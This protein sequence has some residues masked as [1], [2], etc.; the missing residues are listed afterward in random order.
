[1]NRSHPTPRS[2]STAELRTALRGVVGPA[3]PDYLSDIVAEAG[4]TRQRPA[5]TFL[6]RWLPVDIGEQGLGVPRAAVVF[7]VLSLLV[8]LLVAPAV[9]VGSQTKPA[10]VDLGIFA[11]VAGRVVY[12]DERGIWGV[13]A[14]APADGAT[15]VQLTSEAGIPLGWSSDGT[16]LL[17]M[18]GS[19]PDEHL[20]VLHADGSETQ[21]TD[22]PMSIRGATIAPDGSRVVFAAATSEGGSALYAVD[23]QGGSAEVLVVRADSG[24]R[25]PAYSPAGTRI[26]YMSG[27]GDHSNSVWLMN[28]DG[29][30]DHPIVRNE[31]D[32]WAGHVGGLAW[33]PTGEQIALGLGGKIYTFATDGSGFT[34]I[35]GADTTCISPED[36]AINLPKSVVSPY[37]SPDGSQNAYT[38]GCLEGARATNRD[39]CHLAIADADGSN[40]LVFGFA[41]SGPWHP[42]RR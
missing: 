16:R 35:A 13:D 25:A 10:P 33:S 36:C 28:A 42:A 22:R 40:V 1:M 18:R 2:F 8:A 39:G 26:A 9:Y 31:S 12:A 24:I 23:A 14:A 4:R 41:A 17:V 11:P 6:E 34:Q 27:G 38:T 37:W 19:D 30:D 3:R 29:S 21:V 32:T 7:M 15:R 20:F 5:W